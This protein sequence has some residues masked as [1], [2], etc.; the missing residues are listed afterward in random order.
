MGEVQK[1]PACGGKPRDSFRSWKRNGGSVCPQC[2]EA[3]RSHLKLTSKRQSINANAKQIENRVSR[4]LFERLRDWKEHHDISCGDLIGEVK[5][6]DYDTVKNSGG[7]LGI[8]RKALKQC[9]GV[10]GERTPFAVLHIKNTKIE[11]AY[12][13]VAGVVTDLKTFRGWLQEEERPDLS[14]LPHIG[15]V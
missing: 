13:L 7:V 15:E 8:L 4:Y 1:C 2:L 6:A 9:E 12:V 10:C 5:Q 11:T 3:L 14:S